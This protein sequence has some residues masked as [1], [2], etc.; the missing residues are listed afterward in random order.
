MAMAAYG[1]PYRRRLAGG[2]GSRPVLAQGTNGAV[3][4]IPCR[5]RS[6]RSCG[7][8]ATERGESGGSHRS[9]PGANILVSIREGNLGGALRTLRRL[10][11]PELDPSVALLPAF[12]VRGAEEAVL[13]AE[14]ETGAAP[15][16]WVDPAVEGWALLCKLRGHL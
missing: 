11:V 14:R 7:T 2:T 3:R 1:Y 9:V 16:R 5:S 10:G 4:I 15:D 13:A 6:R 12:S 8:G